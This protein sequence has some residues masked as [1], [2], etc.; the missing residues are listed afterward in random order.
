MYKRTSSPE[1]SRLVAM[2]ALDDVFDSLRHVIEADTN[3]VIANLELMERVNINSSNKYRG[4]VEDAKVLDANRETISSIDAEIQGYVESVNQTV[5]QV[6]E[7]EAIVKELDEWS[8]ELSVK[9]RRYGR[10]PIKP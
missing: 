6:D 1:K 7:L 9:C 10:K 4:L 5:K 3:C 8:R 2:S